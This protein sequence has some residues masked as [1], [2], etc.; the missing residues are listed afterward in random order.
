MPPRMVSLIATVAAP[1]G[2]T[3]KA[4]LVAGLR[5]LTVLA[6]SSC[7]DILAGNSVTRVFSLAAFA[8]GALLFGLT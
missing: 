1:C 3:V 5:P 8:T 4:S 2:F 6:F 7:F